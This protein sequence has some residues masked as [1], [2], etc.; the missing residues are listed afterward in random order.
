MG[1]L[2]VTDVPA[3]PRADWAHSSYYRGV[4][5]LREMDNGITPFRF[6]NKQLARYGESEMYGV[7]SRCQSGISLA[8]MTDAEWLELE[9]VVLE[10]IREFV[11]VQ[12]AVNDRWE[13][14]RGMDAIGALPQRLK[15][16]FELDVS[17][18]TPVL[19]P[20]PRKVEI[21]LPHLAHIAI[22]GLRLS[23]GASMQPCPIAADG[24]GGP[25]RRLLCF[26]DSITQG[27]NALNP[28]A[29]YPVR[30]S[31]LLGAECL[32]QGVGGHVFEQDT[33]DDDLTFEADLVTVAY[34]TNDWHRNH[35]AAH[36]AEQA[37]GLLQRIARRYPGK[38]IFL[39]TPVWRIAE[40]ERHAA[41]ALADVRR[42]LSEAADCFMDVRVIPGEILVPPKP[43][44]FAD[45][46]HPT[47]EGFALY[48]NELYR[49]IQE[50]LA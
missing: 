45:G 23:D 44:L 7:R 37:R 33:F 10:S 26:G 4:V 42:L 24:V 38:P 18:Q 25:I 22:A 21:W 43:Y 8:M 39:I 30:L 46:L 34:G 2:R 32:N 31:K 27:A 16:R 15:I 40:S 13:A 19:G 14:L 6:T 47:E 48:T 17:L 29:I 50:I 9:L 49:R 36:I 35:T 11:Y 5:N 12:L 20:K 28:A 41:G 1:E 3:G